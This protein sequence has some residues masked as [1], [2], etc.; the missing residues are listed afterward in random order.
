MKLSNLNIG[1]RLGA[2]FAVVLV[3]VVVIAAVGMYSLS[4]VGT[5]S[6]NVINDDWVKLQAVNAINASTRDN[7]RRNMELFFVHG[8]SRQQIRDSIQANKKAIDDAVAILDSKIISEKGKALLARFKQERA[9]YVNTFNLIDEQV[10]A[11]RAVQARKTL[12]EETLPA[13]TRL[14]VTVAEMVQY[15]TQLTADSAA[16]LKRDLAAAQWWLAIVTAVAIACGVLLA[17]LITRSITRPMRK[18]VT[19][20]RTVASG[21]L[22]S[23]ITVAS[24][25]ET[26]QLLQAL[27]DMNES[28]VGI[29]ARV[30]SGTESMA[31]ASHEIAAGNEDLSTRTEEQ[32]SS[33]TQTAAS[34]EEL[35]ST[36]KQNADNARQAH[37]LASTASSVAQQGGTV[38]SQ[39]VGTMDQIN[40]ASRKIV[41]IISVID[42][43]AFQ[44]NILALNA[45]VEAARAGEQGRGF[46]VVASEVRTLAQRSA[47][48][49]REIKVLIENSVSKVEQGTEQVAAAGKTMNEI[50]DSIQRV[51][52]IMGEITAASNEQ[53]RGIEQVNIAIGQMD[54][55]TQQNAALVEQ[56]AAA[57]LSLQEQARALTQVVS[58]FRLDPA[59]GL[60]SVSPI[61]KDITP[62]ES[63][64]EQAV[65][66]VRARQV[67]AVTHG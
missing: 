33:L 47:S 63:G 6:Q 22:T 53:T 2:G 14:Q 62:P 66:S 57:S 40:Q 60:E 39:A 15:Q 27:K 34:M 50:V 20:A 56:A 41:D 17:W 43:I 12:N 7:A 29:V 16:A 28:L 58:V 36:V 3:L 42:G 13:L 46:A 31:T 26:G 55:V 64:Q 38:V 65:L 48:A 61:L 11:N 51:T 10:S 59:A 54:Q 8:D 45:A 5:V 67:P 23:T 1:T 18:A 9:T 32:A 52:D 19:V 25:D 24:T 44:T 49:A 35:T 37:T 21:D 30:R 4:V